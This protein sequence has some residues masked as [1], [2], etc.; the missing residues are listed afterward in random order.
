MENFGLLFVKQ[1]QN[2]VIST[3]SSAYVILILINLK[4]S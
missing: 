3:L 1:Y 4:S 2:F